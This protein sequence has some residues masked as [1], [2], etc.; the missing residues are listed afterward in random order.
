MPDFVSTYKQFPLFH[1]RKNDSAFRTSTSPA[2]IR[3]REAYKQIPESLVISSSLLRLRSS[4]VHH[5]PSPAEL[6]SSAKRKQV[7]GIKMATLVG[8]PCWVRLRSI[9]EIT[10]AHPS[11]PRQSSPLRVR[12]IA[13]PLPRR[14]FSV[15]A[16]AASDGQVRVRFAPSPTGN[17]HVGG[18]RTALFNYL[19]AR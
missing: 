7:K 9:G 4:Q 14:G 12:S 18:A 2:S 15:S 16:A 8:S 10:L 19:F 5:H 1:T 17:L 3:K 11:F 13:V 6:L